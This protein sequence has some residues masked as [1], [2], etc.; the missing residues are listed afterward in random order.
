MRRSLIK[1]KPK[2]Y[3]ISKEEIAQVEARSGGL[4]EGCGRCTGWLEKAHIKHRGM[5]G[6]QRRNADIINNHRNMADLCIYCHGIIDRR[7]NVPAHFR[8]YLLQKLKPK[9][10]WYEWAEEHGIKEV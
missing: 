9:L 2:R 3:P 10:G 7:I 4:C 5:G 6:V 1:H 8:E